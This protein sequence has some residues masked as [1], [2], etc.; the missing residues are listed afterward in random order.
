MPAP[1]PVRPWECCGESGSCASSYALG[2]VL[3]GHVLGVLGHCGRHCTSSPCFSAENFFLRESWV[4]SIG[5][6]MTLLS[7]A[8]LTAPVPGVPCILQ[9]QW[10]FPLLFQVSRA[11]PGWHNLCP[12]DTTPC[13]PPPPN[14]WGLPV[15]ALTS[16]SG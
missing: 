3:L 8:A 9:I 13:H 5:R 14:A 6:L 15:L 1:M 4:G 11:L 10:L 12:T 16:G 7:R 2:S